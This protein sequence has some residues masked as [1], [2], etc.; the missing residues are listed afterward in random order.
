M[1]RGNREVP[2]EEVI[3]NQLQNPLSR[4]RKSRSRHQHFWLRT[5][6]IETLRGKAQGTTLKGVRKAQHRIRS[7]EARAG[8]REPS[9]LLD[10]VSRMSTGK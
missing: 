3:F 5:P 9:F 4:L 10:P 2:S 1:D 7:V 6:H 8:E